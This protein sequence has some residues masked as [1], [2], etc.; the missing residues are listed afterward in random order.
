MVPA[1]RPP[2][3]DADA[4][5]VMPVLF[6]PEAS[7]WL[8]TSSGRIAGEGYS[9]MQAVHWVAGSGLYEPRRQRSHGPRSFGLT[10]VRVAQELAALFPCRPGIEYLVRR[11]GLSERSVEYHLGML[12]EAGLLAY[13]VRGT[14]VR[15]ESA[16]ASEFA[17]MIPVEF[18]VALGIRTVRR[19][20]DAPAY[21]RA[22]S[23]IAEA[24]RELM[25]KLARK[26]AR[27][28]RKPRSK[29]S[30]KSPARGARKGA[31]QS[32][33]TAVSGEVR[34]TP[35]QVGTSAVSSAGT[36]SFPSESKLASGE[37]KSLTP[38]KSSSKDGGRRKLNAVGRRFQL[39]KELTQELD[40]LRD[41][42]VAR[43]AWVARGVADAGWT[44]TDVKCW[45]HL[46]GEADRVRRGS[47]LL[48]VLLAGAETV[49]DTPQKRA[50]AIE[51]WRS[52]Q[53][54]ARRHRIQQVRARTERYEGDWDAPSSQSV[55]RQVN[56][57]FTAAF[58][59]KPQA[60]APEAET[61]APP[62]VSGME[63]LEDEVV[64]QARAEA[65]QR[66]MLGDT[67]LITVAVDA[68]GREDA[69]QLY[70]PDLVRRALQLVTGARSSRMTYGRR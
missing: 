34:C 21:T 27:R 22:V 50:D 53:E 69:E 51:Q 68:M 26:A 13:I 33:V 25:A 45:L 48:A 46:R 36:T 67:S 35:M 38:K 15:G 18:D 19:D 57:A 6:V 9:W 32:V 56:E 55:Q 70:G 29:M 3:E 4:V 62:A 16:R 47:G 41:C 1:P 20:E 42:S 23:G 58:S 59:P 5:A 14:R 52:A 65:R 28:V 60:A 12:R 43:I 49:L 61:E 8:S 10:T 63:V 66:L 39:A 64:A 11:T 40:W 54:A 37:A 44:V 17:R 30:S 2:V 31:E 7:Q 24:G